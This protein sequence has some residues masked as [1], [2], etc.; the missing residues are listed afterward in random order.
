MSDLYSAAHREKEPGLD[1]SNDALKVPSAEITVTSRAF[2][3]KRWFTIAQE[4]TDVTEAVAVSYEELE[5]LVSVLQE[6]LSRWEPDIAP[7]QLKLFDP[8]ELNDP[9]LDP[10]Q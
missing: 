9:G 10:A 7:E 4:N 6:A 3:G 2:A 5:E 8:E 1:I